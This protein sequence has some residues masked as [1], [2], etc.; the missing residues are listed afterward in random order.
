MAVTISLAYS[1]FKM[2]TENNLVRRIEAAE[3]MG[4][5]DQICSDKTGT[6]T[7]GTM[8]L[9]EVFI[10]ETNYIL[11]R[12]KIKD[13]EVDSLQSKEIFQRALRMNNDAIIEKKRKVFNS[14]R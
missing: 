4:G 3:T 7:E 12:F 8:T 1:V 6:L 10:Q 2:K 14:K 9:V 5:V 13:K 11:D